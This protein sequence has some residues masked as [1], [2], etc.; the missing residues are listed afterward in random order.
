MLT[1]PKPLNK[2]ILL[3]LL[4]GVMFSVYVIINRHVFNTYEVD[5][6]NYVVTFSAVNGLCGLIAI[7]AKADKSKF[8]SVNFKH[9]VYV[10]L[11]GISALSLLAFSQ[12]KTTASNVAVLSSLVIL[13]TS[14]W[15][16]PI[17][18]EKLSRRAYIWILV[19]L[20]AVY[21]VITGFSLL[22][23]NAGDL[24]VLAAVAIFG[25]NNAYAKKIIPE[26][27]GGFIVDFRL[28]LGAAILILMAFAQNSDLSFFI[29]NAGYWPVAAGL[30]SYFTI[31]FTFKAMDHISAT[32]T[33]V[34]FTAHVIFTLVGA[35]IFLGESLT[36]LKLLGSVAILFAIYKLVNVKADQS[37][38]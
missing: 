12:S 22:T 38:S 3:G 21:L 4:S 35:S 2:G 11:L 16:R 20:S 24:I 19:L 32:N 17:L 15:S 27:G 6:F 29:T 37:R 5:A 9:V 1:T 28:A 7:L 31:L 34:L 8:K 18:G 30:F 10:S 36:L 26:F 14:L 13:S 33:L 25:A 23:L